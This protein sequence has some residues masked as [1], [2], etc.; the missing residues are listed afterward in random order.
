MPRQF[1]LREGNGLRQVRNSDA[2][3][4]YRWMTDKRF[5]KTRPEEGANDEPVEQD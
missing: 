1:F 2:A 3:A 5:R 4:L